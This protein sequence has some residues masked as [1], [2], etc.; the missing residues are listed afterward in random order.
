MVFELSQFL[1][2]S[3]APIFDRLFAVGAITLVLEHSSLELLDVFVC[4]TFLAHV[5]KCSIW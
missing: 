5:K 4:G 2:I 1:G 3:L